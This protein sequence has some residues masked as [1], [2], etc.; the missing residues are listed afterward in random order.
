MPDMIKT[1]IV[2]KLDDADCR[3]RDSIVSKKQTET[4]LLKQNHTFPVTDGKDPKYV[5]YTGEIAFA[6]WLH[7]PYTYKPYDKLDADVMGYQIKTTQR[8]SGCLIKQAHMPR[9][10]YVF[11]TVNDALDTVTF[12]GWIL[13]EEIHQE[14][15]WRSDVPK[16]AYFVPQSEL[17]SMSELTSTTELAAF[18]G[19]L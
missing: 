1:E 18:H 12:K 16:P 10:V 8:A 11:G 9:G 2:I 3:L 13:S 5:G 6:K 19:W 17:W 4:K 15:Y 14:C 7:V